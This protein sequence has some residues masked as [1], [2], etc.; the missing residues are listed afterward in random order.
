MSASTEFDTGP[1]AVVVPADFA[2]ALN[3]DLG[4]RRFFDGLTY[5][6]KRWHVR[7]IEGA[8]TSEARQ[9]RI[10]KSVTMLREGRARGIERRSA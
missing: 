2:A 6:S 4:A 3:R 5:S 10:G 8:R 1:R 7:S 9:R